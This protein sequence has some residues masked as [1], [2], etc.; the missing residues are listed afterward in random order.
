MFCGRGPKQAGDR[1]KKRVG[2]FG[3][4]ASGHELATPLVCVLKCA[5]LHEGPTSL[6]YRVTSAKYSCFPLRSE[7]H[8]HA[9]TR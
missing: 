7:E 5:S 8:G 6:E 4:A 2:D 1:K 3:T 9:L